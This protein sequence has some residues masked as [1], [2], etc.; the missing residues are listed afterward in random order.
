MTFNASTPELVAEL[1]DEDRCRRELRQLRPN[2]G[3]RWIVLSDGPL[4][5]CRFPVDPYAA[6]DSSAGVVQQSQRGPISVMYRKQ[7]SGEWRFDGLK[8]VGW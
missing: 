2:P 8:A 1:F 3:D 4:A 7:P 6:V 5:G